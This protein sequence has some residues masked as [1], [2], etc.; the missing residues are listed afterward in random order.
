MFQSSSQLNWSLDQAFF[1]EEKKKVHS[2]FCENSSL[3]VS[4]EWKCQEER[5]NFHNDEEHT[6]SNRLKLRKETL[7]FISWT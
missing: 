5:L 6:G 7:G 4:A 2:L 1:K 3:R